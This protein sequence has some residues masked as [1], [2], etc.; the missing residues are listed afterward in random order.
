MRTTRTTSLL[1]GINEAPV[2]GNYI[3]SANR[4]FVTRGVVVGVST[5]YNKTT[6]TSALVTT[7]TA[8]QINALGMVFKPGD[9]FQVSLAAP[10]MVQ[11]D[12]GLV[13]DVE[14]NRCGF[15]YPDKEL[16][17][18]LCVTCRDKPKPI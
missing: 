18:G 14:C 7:V 3:I 4:D 5:L 6:D 2:S 1:E 17:R 11:T 8:T 12:D 9:F 13:V 10:W 15:S 16:I